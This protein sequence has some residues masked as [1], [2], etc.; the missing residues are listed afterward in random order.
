MGYIDDAANVF[1][2]GYLCIKEQRTVR[3]DNT[4][5]YEGK[6]Y[7][8]QKAN[9]AKTVMMEERLDI[10]NETRSTRSFYEA[11]QRGTFMWH[12]EASRRMS[13]SFVLRRREVEKIS[14]SY[15]AQSHT[16]EWT[17]FT[18]NRTFLFW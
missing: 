13:V 4:V 7:L 2:E 17:V 1:L 10:E 16:N 12:C 9:N 15:T 11:N 18:Q 5:S 6:L 3:N 14:P 8:I